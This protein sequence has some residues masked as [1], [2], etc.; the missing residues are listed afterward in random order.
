MTRTIRG[1]KPKT[2]EAYRRF[3]KLN[4]WLKRNKNT[5]PKPASPYTVPLHLC[6]DGCCLCEDGEVHVFVKHSC[7]TEDEVR[8]LLKGCKQLG[9]KA[10]W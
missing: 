7:M 8:W 3:K 4:A 6:F 10:E 5:A 9:F 1:I 2:L